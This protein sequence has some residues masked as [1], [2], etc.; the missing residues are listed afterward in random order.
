[1]PG[2]W[3]RDTRFIEHANSVRRTATRASRLATVASRSVSLPSTVAV[4]PILITG[5]TGTLGR[6]FARICELRGLP[7]RLVSRQDMDICNADAV[8]AALDIYGPKAVINGAGYVRVD[9]AELDR[10]ACDRDNFR[11]ARTLADVCG[12]RGIPLV[13]FSSDL[14]FNGRADKPYIEDDATSP[15]SA[16]GLSKTRAEQSVMEHHPG[17][18]VIR[19]SAFFGPWDNHNFLT[20]SLQALG[21]GETVRAARDVTVSPTYIPDLVHASLDLFLD[22]EAGLWHL[23]NRGSTSWFEFAR[24]AAIRARISVHNL[25]GVPASSLGWRAPRPP[26]SVLDSCRGSIMPSLDDALARY[27]RDAEW[28]RESIARPRAVRAG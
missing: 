5:A 21:G 15:V 18:L 16:Y 26:Y 3:E 27:I 28:Q 12:G 22:G 4:P 19:T 13:T 11:G 7:Y 9:D 2:W 10:E 8:N 23:A 14:V 17:A 20:V 25:I 24:D 1:M 6:A